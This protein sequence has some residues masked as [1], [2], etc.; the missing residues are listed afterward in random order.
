MGPLVLLKVSFKYSGTGLRMWLQS[1]FSLS[2]DSFTLCRPSGWWWL[3]IL[4]TEVL[5]GLSEICKTSS[6]DTGALGSC[7]LPS[8]IAVDVVS[9]KCRLSEMD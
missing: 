1:V 6:I 9:S 7:V 5:R 2:R 3:I 8:H 4:H